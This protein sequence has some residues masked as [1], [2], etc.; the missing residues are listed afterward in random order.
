[1]SLGT[2][3]IIF[4]ILAA[5][6]FLG[7]KDLPRLAAKAGDWWNQFQRMKQEVLSSASNALADC[8]K[9]ASVSGT[10]TPQE[11]HSFPV[12]TDDEVLALVQRALGTE[13]APAA[14]TNIEKPNI[15]KEN[16]TAASLKHFGESRS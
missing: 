15:V 16:T 6:V 8:D 2:P 10:N 7:P 14:R 9:P 11:A 12:A 5:L 1:M 13:P 4:V 3:E